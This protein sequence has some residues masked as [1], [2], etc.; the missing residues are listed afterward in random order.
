M[1]WLPL[2]RSVTVQSERYPFA[3]CHAIKHP[4][5][6]EASVR[7]LREL[8]DSFGGWTCFV[9]RDESLAGDAYRLTVQNGRIV[10][11]S[12]TPRGAFYA[13]QTV[14]N[15]WDGKSL[16][17]LE[18]QDEP[19]LAWR[20]I[21]EGFYGKPWKHSARL[22][23]LDWMG[24][25]KM[26]LYLYAPKDD[27]FH[28]ERWRDPYPESEMERLVELIQ[29]AKQNFIEFVFCISP[30]LSMVYSDPA[31]FERLTAKI[32]AVRQHGV[33]TFGLLVDDIPETLQHEAD[34]QTY[35]SLAHAHADLANRLHTWLNER[36]PDSWL[37]VCPTFYHNRGEPPY[38]R[39]LG[40][41][42]HHDISIMWT[43]A[44][45]VSREITY[46]DA[47]LFRSAIRRKPF[48]WDNYPVNDYE[49][50]RL[51]MGPITQR[52]A[53]ALQH[54]E[55]LVSNPMNQAEASKVALGT[56][57]DLLWNP[58]AYDPQRSWHASIRHL[59]G[60]EAEEAF[61]YFCQQNLWSRHWS[62]EPP[63]I[64]QAIE[65]W[66]TTGEAEPLE[67]ELRRLARLP[68][69]LRQ[70]LHDRELLE[71]IEPWLWR[72]ENISKL[73]LE[74]LEQV[75]EDALNLRHIAEEIEVIRNASEAVV[76]DGWIERWIRDTLE[77]VRG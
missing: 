36:D 10:I 47:E 46:E 33:R 64:A 65:F 55:T 27:P 41:R 63:P 76:C 67:Q 3:G 40:E 22:K 34:K 77:E 38:V 30:G 52:S 72:L 59:V 11:Q 39:E 28:R 19:F 1:D 50:S 17:L 24:K 32:E 44:K 35:T 7:P 60:E 6:W 69:T 61:A 23:M 4:L 70:V 49:P 66:Q 45:V 58:T 56:Y 71:E 21:V 18:V 73:A 75:Q 15:A 5:G 26:N 42:T 29:R 74:L 53:E 25:Y 57:A 2:P 12:G 54:L 48:V 68:A 43:G 16:P 8:G 62:A 9:E 37:I 13:C 31:E 14:L 20:G 51:L